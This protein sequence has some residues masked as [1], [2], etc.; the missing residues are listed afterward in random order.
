MTREIHTNLVKAG[1]GCCGSKVKVPFTVHIRFIGP[2][3]GSTQNTICSPIGRPGFSNGSERTGDGARTI[4]LV[5]VKN[6]DIK[7]E[8]QSAVDMISREG[9]TTTINAIENQYDTDPL[10]PRGRTSFDRPPVGRIKA[11]YGINLPTEVAAVYR[12]HKAVVDR[13]DKVL[14]YHCLDT[15]AHVIDEESGYI[16]KGGKLLETANTVQP[17][18]EK[19]SGDGTVPYWSMQHVKTWNSKDCIVT[20]DTLDGAPHRE[21][22]ADSRFHDLLIS[23]VCRIKDPDEEKADSV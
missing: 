21:I 15:Q 9:V 18:G 20:V 11:V 2:P 19:V 17:D 14:N 22:L 5:H 13:H 8:A 10:D 1:G 3:E 16:T 7:Y 6:Q 23:Y 12:R 4:N